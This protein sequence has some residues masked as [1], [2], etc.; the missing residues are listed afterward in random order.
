M[1]R[2]AIIGLGAV[3]HNI[4][5][6]AYTRLKDKVSI[7][8]G[9]D[10]DSSMSQ[11]TREKWHVKEVYDD[12]E[13][14]IKRTKPDIISICTPPSLHHRQTLMALDY[15]CHVFCE[16]PLAE[17]LE[18]ADEMIEAAERAG[19]FVVVNNQFPYMNIHRMSKELI[20]TPKFGQLLYLHAW[21]TFRA[22]EITED[23]WR[24]ELHRR[25][26]F[27][28]GTHVFELIRF[29]FNDNPVK[30]MAHMPNPLAS[31][32]SDCINMIALEFAD[33]RAASIVLDRLSKGPE[34]YLD[35]RLDGERASIHT[36]IGGAIQFAAGLHT[37]EKRPFFRFD[38]VQGGKAVLQNGNA[39]E[40]I[41]KDAINPLTSATAFHFE[42]FINALCSGRIPPGTVKDNRNTLALVFAAYDSAESDRAIEMSRY[43]ENGR[44]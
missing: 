35:M 5:M 17:S 30:I 14:M 19:R 38:L 29:F 13:E 28:F 26:C 41:A 15:G 44:K 1:I 7:V 27:E 34:R 36:T 42:N 3:T 10:P 24:G 12:A 18:Q 2:V 37:R 20:G 25:L 23:G 40:L 6:P 33:G 32:T 16:K 9:A 22:T 31:A 21:Q 43:L 11:L 4:H 39:S 8:A